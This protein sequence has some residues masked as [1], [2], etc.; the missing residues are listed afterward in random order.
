M[1]IPLF[2]TA[3]ILVPALLLGC[4]DQPG[5]AE[6]TPAPAPSLRTD[7]NPEGPGA[8]VIRGPI[9]FFVAPASGLTTI[10]GLRYEQLLEF[11][12]TNEPPIVDI[13]FL[14]VTRP[15]GAPELA[16]VKFL[17]HGAQLPLLVWEVEITGPDEMCT[18]LLETPHLSGTGQFIGTDNDQLGTGTRGNAAHFAIRGQVTSDAGERFRLSWVVK[19]LL[20]PTGEL[21]RFTVDA[22]LDPIG[23]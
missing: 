11:C 10:I 16:D 3:A 6:P 22:E 4:G 9:D 14:S 15:H 23:P 8:F 5:P 1:R 7:Q 17:V 12:A 21:L 2:T 13:E 19:F 20:L 18:V